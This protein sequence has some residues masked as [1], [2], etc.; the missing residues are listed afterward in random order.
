MV[1]I[2]HCNRELGRTVEFKYLPDIQNE[3]PSWFLSQALR[4]YLRAG[5][6]DL[7]LMSMQA[8]LNAMSIWCEKRSRAGSAS[9]ETIY[10]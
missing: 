9:S 1:G 7:G 3:K 2:T 10:M 4:G 6:M 5:G 8:A